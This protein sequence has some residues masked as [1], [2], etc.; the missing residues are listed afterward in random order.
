[1]K[2]LFSFVISSAHTSRGLATQ[3][4]CLIIRTTYEERNIN[5]LKNLSSLNEEA[6]HYEK[7]QEKQNN[8]SLYPAWHLP[9]KLK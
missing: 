5:M 7:R 4:L 6:M 1:M 9:E 8:M 2:T 3:A